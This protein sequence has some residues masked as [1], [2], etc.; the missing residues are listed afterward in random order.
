MED[1]F[2]RE[3]LPHL[4]YKLE[5]GRGGRPGGYNRANTM[6]LIPYNPACHE[7]GWP[8]ATVTLQVTV[9]GHEV[10]DHDPHSCCALVHEF[11][12]A[13]HKT[14]MTIAL[15]QWLVLEGEVDPAFLDDMGNIVNSTAT[16]CLFAGW[17]ESIAER[18]REAG[19][20]GD[21]GVADVIEVLNIRP[22]PA[23]TH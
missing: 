15:P 19:F 4:P 9:M 1:K 16:A 14:T 23:E 13:V 12:V 3:W 11:I 18:C 17:T 20:C 21:C 10:D 2:S 5:Y 8:L 6:K 7:A 22:L